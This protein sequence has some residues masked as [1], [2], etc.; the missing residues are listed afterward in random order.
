MN[1]RRDRADA[2]IVH[3]HGQAGV[4]PQRGFDA[5]EILMLGEIGREDFNRA[6][7][8]ITDPC[9]QRVKTTSIARDDSQV[10]AATRQPF[11]IS[12]ADPTRG[13]GDQSPT[14][15]LK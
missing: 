9:S 4:L 11:R 2:G 14:R 13:S 5:C 12:S 3:Q 8:V 1:H 10:V 7:G 6:A 15:V